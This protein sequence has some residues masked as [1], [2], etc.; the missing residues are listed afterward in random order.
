MFRFQTPDLLFQLEP[1]Y[2]TPSSFKHRN[3]T[4][5]ILG[6]LYEADKLSRIIL[7]NLKY[8]DGSY[9]WAVT[10][11]IRK[12]LRPKEIVKIWQRACRKLRT[13]GFVGLWVIEPH[14]DNT[15]H[16]HMIAISH[17]GQRKQLAK[18][19]EKSMPPRSEV[20]YHKQ[21][22]PIK[23]VYHWTRYMTKA[24][25]RGTFRGRV[26]QDKY[27]KKRL[28]FISGIRLQKSRE[29]GSFWQKPKHVLWKEIVDIEKKISVGLEDHRVRDLAHHVHELLG[30]TVPMNRIE[31]AL[32]YSSDKPSVQDWIANLAGES[33]NDFSNE[34][35][36]N[37]H[38]QTKKKEETNER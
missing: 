30:Q 13:G 18:L 15:I 2:A 27:A 28:L 12:V 31:R 17:G 1:R 7:R 23:S 16:Y 35:I 4:T 20:P 19:I 33:P 34:K 3:W 32:G 38:F 10:I 5:T 36:S 24:K 8:L 29:I 11:K 9:T 37:R 6:Y 21:V 25:T 26:V 22:A 14:H